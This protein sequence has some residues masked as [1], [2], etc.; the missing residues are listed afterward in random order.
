MG[1]LLRIL[2]EEW[3]DR[4]FEKRVYYT[5]LKRRWEIGLECFFLSKTEVGDSI[6]GYGILRDYKSKKEW[7]EIGGEDF[8]EHPWKT[9]LIFERVVKFRNPIPIKELQLDERLK[10]KYLHGLKIDQSLTNK[11]LSRL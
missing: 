1:I 2:R 11:I 9:I 7:L 6:I 10:G 3:V 4:V 8:T 5:S